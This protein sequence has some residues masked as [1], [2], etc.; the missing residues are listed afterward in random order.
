MA[1]NYLLLYLYGGVLQDINVTDDLDDA[2]AE[3]AETEED[4]D[5]DVHIIEITGDVQ[6]VSWI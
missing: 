4:E 1:K 5:A 3:E 2:R 6:G